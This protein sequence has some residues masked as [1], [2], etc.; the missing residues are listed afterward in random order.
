[1]SE[2]EPVQSSSWSN[3]K[4]IAGNI[5]EGKKVIQDDALSNESDNETFGVAKSDLDL[6]ELV[7]RVNQFVHS[8]STKLSF[9]FDDRVNRPIIKVI[10]E[11]T[12]E[13]IRQ[14]PPEEMLARLRHLFD[15]TGIVFKG[16]V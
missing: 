7:S 12:G 2:I 6:P 9:H 15:A 13:V 1:M 16:K 3:I 11:E 10:N 5:I 4:P 8:F 14:I